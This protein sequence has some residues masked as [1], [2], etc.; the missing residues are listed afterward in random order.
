MGAGS[1]RW[2]AVVVATAG[3]AAA[4]APAAGAQAPAPCAHDDATCIGE[5]KLEERASAECRRVG[6][7][8]A[9][10]AD[11]ACFPPNGR[12][13]DRAKVAAHAGT[14]LHRALAFQYALGEAL[15][16]RDAPWLGTHNSFNSTGEFPT[17]SHTDS[18]QQ[19]SLVDQLTLDMRSLEIDVHWS[20][21]P[22]AAPAT[23]APVVCH[24]QEQ[25]GI[26][27]GCTSERLLGDVLSGVAGWLNRPENRDQ[28]L[29]LYLE[30]A[31][32]G[33]E[34]VARGVLDA[35]L[36]RADGTPLVYRAGATDADC[37]SLPLTLTR[38]AVLDAGAQVVI[39]GN[40]GTGW[41]SRV[42]AWGGNVRVEERP[43]GYTAQNC[44]GVS[45]TTY[46]TRL[47]RFFED[48][49]FLTPAAAQLSG[50]DLATPDDGIDPATAAAMTRCGVDLL[51]LDQLL[52]DDGRLDS[53]VWSWG[54]GKPAAA[55]GA[56]A[57]QGADGRW[58]T[59]ACAP[60][61]V[62]ACRLPD[63]GWTTTAEPVAWDGAAAACASQGAEFDLPRT[64]SDNA[65]LRTAAPVGE[66][67]V[68]HRAFAETGGTGDN[69]A[70][71]GTGQ[72]G[73]S[74]AA[75]P[76]ATSPPSPARPVSR[77]AS[78]ACRV[79]PARARVARRTL[80]CRIRL[81]PGATGTATLSLTRGTRTHARARR[82]L[83]AGGGTVTVRT[84]RALTPGAYAVAITLTGQTRAR[85]RRHIAVR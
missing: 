69:G 67:W 74:P 64:G 82:A 68:A 75:A 63:G 24:A 57:L 1:S 14:W 56:C 77:A 79:A 55:D 38:R 85:L 34:D 7:A 28:V 5:R 16:F 20:P 19:L 10:I 39:V 30:N 65:R 76:T 61:R 8:G 3:L 4:L 11:P 40:C 58:T 73:V 15:P 35:T 83:R 43:Q 37:R 25:Q 22:R 45:A 62:A 84:A 13:V 54:P 6:D 42:F 2:A 29:L 36:K 17:L 18:N 26:H 80:V 47:V 21:S 44:G 72:T 59:G 9:P 48:S 70:G 50:G 71:N 32:D 23:A 12:R 53:V 46:A 81:A 41:N 78:A 60:P 66:V 52:P 27:A 31:L 33:H 51:G 49:T